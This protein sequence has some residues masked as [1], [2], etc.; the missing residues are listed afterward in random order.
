MNREQLL[1]AVVLPNDTI[2]KGY[3]LIMITCKDGKTFSGSVEKENARELQLRGADK[4]LTTI[5]L[6]QIVQRTTPT[7]MMPPM[8]TMLQKRELRDL[9]EYLTTLK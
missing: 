6:D 5:A 7:S 3:D 9:I 1:E 8:D 2:A 4:S